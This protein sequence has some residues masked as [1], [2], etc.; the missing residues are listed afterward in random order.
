MSVLL[1]VSDPHFGTEVPG[2]VDAL[3]RLV[4]VLRPQVLV[5]SG[6]ITQRATTAQF[7]AARA[8]VDRLAVPCRLVLP[9]NH[10]I[11]LFDLLSRALRPYARY[12]AVFGADRAPVVEDDRLLLIGVDATRPWRHVD[13]TLSH[14]QIEATA[15]RLRAA[16]PSQLRVVV[17]HQPLYVPDPREAHDLAHGHDQALRAWAAAGADV[18]MG[19]H[20][21]LPFV[22]ALHER[23]PDL[24]RRLWCVQAGTAVSRRTRPGIPNSVWALRYAD[25]P[26]VSIERWDFDSAL[27]AFGQVS[28]QALHLQRDEA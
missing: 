14:A 6:D 8:F 15:R 21:H 25:V 16:R 4:R 5:V 20:I 7:R 18:V 10:D 9:G 13:G 24:P 23:R 12:A 2:V 17:T 22:A 28:T 11:P 26:T 27:D 1:H 3:E 19:G